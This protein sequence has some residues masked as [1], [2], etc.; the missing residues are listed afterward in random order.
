MDLLEK[1]SLITAKKRPP[2]LP[3]VGRALRNLFMTALRFP[4]FSSY[5]NSMLI[6]SYSKDLSLPGERIGFI[7]VIPEGHLK[8]WRRL[9]SATG[10]LAL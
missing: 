2:G 1:P 9:T 7:A 5:P 4:A 3:L 8:K 6:T 10:I